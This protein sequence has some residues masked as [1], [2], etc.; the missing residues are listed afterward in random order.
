MGLNAK[1]AKAPTG[2]GF[3]QPALEAGVYPGR[4]VQLI[5]LGVQKQPDYKGQPKDPAQSMYTTYELLDEFCID[6]DG[7]VLKDKPR[8]ISEDFVLY[9]LDSDLAKC[10]KRYN[11][12]DPDHTHEG[13]W[14]QLLGQPCVVNITYKAGTG[15]HEGKEFNN[16]ESIAPMRPNQVET[17]P[18]LVNPT[19]LF[20]LDDPDVDVFMALP[21]WLQDRIKENLDFEGSDLQ[22]AIRNYKA[23][24]DSETTDQV[25]DT[26]PDP[27]D[28]DE[29]N[30]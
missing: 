27:E 3:K 6:E 18:Q 30:W 9:P 29:D 12:L 24:E 20:D 28:D 21:K 11:V 19:K 7:K 8:W 22:D 13:D 1:N 17:A 2:G 14:T 5:D 15:K 4:L 16:I 23:P 25:E 10:T 26:Q